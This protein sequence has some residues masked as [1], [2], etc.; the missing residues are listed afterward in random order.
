MGKWGNGEMGKWGNGEMGKWG[1]GEMGKWGN[2]KWGNGEMG[3]WGKGSAGTNPTTDSLAR[4]L[5][6]AAGAVP[7]RRQGRGMF[8]VKELGKHG[9]KGDRQ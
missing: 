7:E 6:R 1:N 2:G 4:S 8:G 3:K 9:S 5:K